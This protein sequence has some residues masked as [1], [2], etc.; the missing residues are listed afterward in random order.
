MSGRAVLSSVLLVMMLLMGGMA[1]P[2]AIGDEAAGEM[3]PEPQLLE[4]HNFN[5]TKYGGFVNEE[6][7]LDINNGGTLIK[8]AAR[9]MTQG[10]SYATDYQFNIHYVI[11]GTTYIAQLLM[12]EMGLIVDGHHMTVG[13]ITSDD[14]Q[15]SYTPIVYEGNTPTLWCNISFNNIRVYHEDHPESTI[16]LTLSHHIVADWNRTIIK[17]EAGFDLSRLVLFDGQDSDIEIEDGTEFA[18]EMQY[19]MGVHKANSDDGFLSPS[20]FSNTTL[21]YNL[22]T[23]S[24]APLTISSMNM[25]NDFAI[26]NETSSYAATAYSYLRFD[27]GPLSIHGF[28]GLIYNDTMSLKSDPE[29]TV[30]HDRES[31]EEGQSMSMT[32]IVGGAIIAA[33]VVLVALI[34]KKKEWI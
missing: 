23:D 20:S 14:L 30:Y 24:G 15:L 6:W 32:M 22:T 29:I 11:G 33:A 8:L 1:V 5:E 10:Q 26:S 12:M 3:V 13:L 27:N 31:G 9:N 17:V 18:V 25:K 28:P 7:A 34:A 21:E 16:D 4:W 2:G 19:R